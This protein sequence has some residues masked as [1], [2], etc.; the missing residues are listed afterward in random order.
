MR[1]E[2]IKLLLDVVEQKSFTNAGIINDYTQSAVS[3]RIKKLEEE[4][5]VKLL[6]RGKNKEVIPTKEERKIHKELKT[7]VHVY[8]EILKKKGK[9]LVEIG[10]STGF[11]EEKVL[12][13]L[14]KLEGLNC[15]VKVKIDSSEW[16]YSEFKDN[17]L[18]VVIIGMEKSTF[19]NV[20]ME[21]LFEEQIILAGIKPIGNFSI[22]TLYKIPL[23]F[24]QQ[25]SGL[26]EFILDRF[27]EMNI[28]INKLNIKYEIGYSNFCIEAAKKGYGYTFLPEKECKYPLRE[29]WRPEKLKRNFYLFSRNIELIKRI[30]EVAG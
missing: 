26:K 2:D 22:E 6:Y 13:I 11:P 5:G 23:I 16:L 30:K 25:G 3:K 18:D 29:I 14:E 15:E 9:R 1:L 4:L 24:H 19:S 21:K 10:F 28:N 27:K 7:L 17:R 8:N 12:K 20:C